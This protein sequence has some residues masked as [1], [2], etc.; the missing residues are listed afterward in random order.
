M[1]EFIER[2]WN[3]TKDLT[4]ESFVKL[5]SNWG[6][7]LSSSDLEDIEECALS[8]QSLEKW[9]RYQVDRVGLIG[10]VAGAVVGPTFA[11]SEF[12]DLTYCRRTAIRACLGIGYRLQGNVNQKED[13]NY[14][15]GVWTDV[16]EP[17]PESDNFNPSVVFIKAVPKTVGKVTVKT[18]LAFVPG[19]ALKSASTHYMGKTPAKFAAKLTGKIVNKVVDKAAAKLLTKYAAKSSGLLN[20]IAGAA[21]GGGINWWLID[22]LM[23]AAET[24]YDPNC[25]FLR[26]RDE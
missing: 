20:P 24:Y 7:K 4:H 9:R 26:L 18:T 8:A 11:L 3:K 19:L 1:F 10:S 2:A 23:D 6:S 25:R 12:L 14:I 22:S 15:L 13:L 5:F 21:A 16:L 17:I